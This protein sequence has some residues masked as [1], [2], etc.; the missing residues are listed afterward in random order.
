MTE[1][2]GKHAELG[3]RQRRVTRTERGGT[4][5]RRT[6][7]VDRLEKII[8]DERS[9]A[10]LAASEREAAAKKTALNERR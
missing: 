7:E 8:A 6:S 2:E 3:R 1:A 4:T 5:G 9:A 10:E